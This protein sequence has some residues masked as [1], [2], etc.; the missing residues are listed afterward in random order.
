MQTQAQSPL[1]GQLTSS[2]LALWTLTVGPLLLQDIAVLI[3]WSIPM[4]GDKETDMSRSWEVK[5]H[6]PKIHHALLQ[7]IYFSLDVRV[8]PLRIEQH[9]MLHN[10]ALGEYGPVVEGMENVLSFRFSKLYLQSDTPDSTSIHYVW[11]YMQGNILR[12]VGVLQCHTGPQKSYRKTWDVLVGDASKHWVTSPGTAMQPPPTVSHRS[13]SGFHQET[14][15]E[16]MQISGMRIS[17]QRRS[18]DKWTS[19]N[20][21]AIGSG[22]HIARC[23]NLGVVDVEPDHLDFGYNILL[24]SANFQ[25]SFVGCFKQNKWDDDTCTLQGINISHLVKRKIIFKMPFLGDMLVSWRVSVQPFGAFGVFWRLRPQRCNGWK[26][27]WHLLS[28]EG[29]DGHSWETRD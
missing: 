17:G 24:L 25:V 14:S 16:Q 13:Q 15:K 4:S 18:R 1:Q 9:L 12:S 8:C 7:P 29:H 26:G 22:I 20:L 21:P 23:P 19:N 2:P 28:P 3:A 27:T 5:S 11:M 6:T 10:N